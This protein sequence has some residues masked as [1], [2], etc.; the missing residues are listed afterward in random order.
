V[1]GG[2]PP[3]PEEKCSV[4]DGWPLKRSLASIRSRRF[5][6]ANR[7]HWLN[8]GCGTRSGL[9]VRSGTAAATMRCAKVPAATTRPSEPVATAGSRLR[10]PLTRTSEIARVRAS[11][12]D[13]SERALDRRTLSIRVHSSSP[14]S[15]A[16]ASTKAASCMGTLLTFN[17]AMRWSPA[18]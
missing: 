1:S 5:W 6:F 4:V 17:M 3:C 14:R 7:F 12:M 10:S 11:R 9:G 15:G 2:Q 18:A 8:D 13:E 16:S